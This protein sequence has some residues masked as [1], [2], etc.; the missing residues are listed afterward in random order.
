MCISWD[1]LSPKLW[2]RSD[3]FFCGL[4]LF[5]AACKF[6]LRSDSSLSAEGLQLDTEP[7]TRSRYLADTVPFYG[8]GDAIPSERDLLAK[9]DTSGLRAVLQLLLRSWPYIAPQILGRW[10]LPGRGSEDRVAEPLGGRGFSFGYMPIVVTLLAIAVPYS[11]LITFSQAYPLNLLYGLIA[12]TVISAWPLPFLEGRVQVFSLISLLAATLLANMVA[13][14]LVEDEGYNLY[15]GAITF[16]CVLGWF[17][18]I[19][20]NARGIKYRVRVGTHLIYYPALQLIQGLGFMVVTLLVAE[21]INQSLLQNDPLMPGLS[22]ML[23][24]PEMS[25]DVTEALTDVERMELRW[26]PVQIELL[27]FLVLVPLEIFMLWYVVWIFQRVNHDLRLALVE[28]WHRLSLRHHADHRVGDSIWRIQADSE[29][30]V[31]VVKSILELLVLLANVFAA[32]AFISILSPILGLLIVTVLVPTLVVARWAMPRYRTRSLVERRA[33]ADLMS[34]IQESF[35]SI[36][37]SK[38]YQA[39]AHYQRQFEEDSMIAFNAEYRHTRLQLRVG[40]IVDAYSEFFIFAGFFLMAYW[41]NADEPTFATELIALAGMTFVVWNLSAFRWASER[42]EVS[43]GSL[44]D[45]IKTWGWVQDVAMGLQRV[46]DIL[47]MQPEV[48]DRT[49]AVTFE[50]FSSEISF[51]NVEFAYSG[52]RPVLQGVSFTAEPGT[53]TAIVGPSGS[54][55]ST[56]MSLLLRLFDP[57]QGAISIDGTDLRDFRVDSLRQN[58]AIALQENVLFGMTVR[59]NICYAVPDAGTAQIEEALRIACFDDAVAELP[60]GLDTLL[61]DRGG[62]L[63]TGQRQRIS[64]ARA[65][66]RETPILILDEPTAALDAETEREVLTNLHAWATAGARAIFLI[67]HRISTIRQADNIVFLDSGHV[68]ESGDHDRLMQIDGGRYSEFVRSETASQDSVDV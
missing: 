7:V 5:D 2:G 68:V 29:T 66:V 8:E 42:F 23:G 11:G 12:V 40:V 54:G 13:I 30:V 67:T 43:I 9:N 3:D 10:W 58:I 51:N 1:W 56:L 16:V 24:Y 36:R 45:V 18:Q 34:R 21:I 48:T 25:Q 44:G 26:A 49:D 35:R 20:Y 63:S 57:D 46:F 32:L 41:V 31:S 59:Q 37:L 50:G 6:S 14:V 65:V 22:A 53:I 62:R 33:N 4:I 60:D 19:G 52:D 28:R 47:D 61:G 17:V 27:W 64:I 38:A 39:G 15:T 55:K